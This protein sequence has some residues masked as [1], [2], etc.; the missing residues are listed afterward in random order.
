[1][2]ITLSGEAVLSGGL[3]GAEAV[4]FTFQQHDQAGSDVV[5]RGDDQFAS[6][7]DDAAIEEFDFHDAALGL[8]VAILPDLGPRIHKAARNVK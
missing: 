8:E 3:G 7:P 5:V 6:G 2:I 4:T 1:L